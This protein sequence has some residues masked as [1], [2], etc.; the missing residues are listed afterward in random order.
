MLADFGF[1]QARG[2]LLDVVDQVIDD[3]VIPDLHALLRRRGPCRGIRPHVEAD[4]RRLAGIGQTDVRIG[5][6]ADARMQNPH[7][8]LVVADLFQ[9]LHDGFRRT[10]HIRLHQHRQ[11]RHAQIRLGLGHQLFQRRRGAHG[12]AFVLARLLAVIRDLA[13]LRFGIDHVQRIARPR[14]AGQTQHFDRHG[15]AGFGDHLALVI[16]QRPHLAPLLADDK[17]VALAQGAVLHQ[18]RRHRAT[19]R[20]QLGLDHRTRRLTARVGAQ[21]QQFGLQRDGFQQRVQPFAGLGRNFDILH[22]ARHLLD[23]DGMLQ[24]LLAHLVRV[25][26]IF[27]DLVD[28]HD[29]R[30]L[31]RLRMGN[32]LDRLRHHRIVRR[33]HQHY[34]IGDIRPAR[35]HRGEG[36]VTRRVKEGDH[37]PLVGFHLIGADMLGDPARFAR[38]DRGLADRIQQRGLAVVDMAHDRDDRRAMYQVFGL[39]L[40]HVDGLLDVGVSDAGRLVAKFLDHQFGGVGVDGLVGRD[41]H[42]HLHQR[43]DH[44]RRPFGHAVGKFCHRDRLGQLHIAHLLF[45]FHAKAHRLLAGLFLLALDRGHRPLATAFVRDRV[46]QRQLARPAAILGPLGL[47]GAVTFFAF[48]VGL[49]L[50]QGTRTRRPPPLACAG[51]GIVRRAGRR[52]TCRGGP[53][54]RAG[55]TIR[56]RSVALGRG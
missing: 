15:R 18:H 56:P 2:R 8:N 22:I 50:R 7:P 27:V 5:D 30:H 33:H 40:D 19:A 17:D 29:Q 9:R 4:D 54:R 25:R 44:I 45:G 36:R 46:R 28:R 23:D 31:G 35:A 11:F 20:V 32:R 55:R 24:Q 53:R 42:A 48:A 49:A 10:L 6:R 52:R 26:L 1:Q 34:D 3:R 39:V 51:R 12:C 37:L 38:H 21:L 47:G 14:R 16:D 13:R 43:F 41:H